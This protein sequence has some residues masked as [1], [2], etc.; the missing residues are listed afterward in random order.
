VPQSR[1]P[2]GISP[3]LLRQARGRTRDQLGADVEGKA[4]DE[5]CMAFAVPPGGEAA[6][7][8]FA[9]AMRPPGSGAPA[10]LELAADPEPSEL[11]PGV[12][13]AV[14]TTGACRRPIACSSSC[15]G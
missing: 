4:T 12:E 9:E 8:G 10:V 1:R 2:D 14:A 6:A 11:P 3:E 7:G 13:A 5:F 15:A